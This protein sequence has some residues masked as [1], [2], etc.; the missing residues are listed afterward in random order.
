LSPTQ[1]YATLILS[2]ETTIGSHNSM[3]RTPFQQLSCRVLL[4]ED[5][6][7]QAEVTAEFI[8]AY[9]LEVRI[10]SSGQHALEMA[11]TFHPEIVL[12]D[13]TLPD[14]SGLDVL[15]AMRSLESTRN[16]LL[17]IYS[18]RSQRDLNLL[19]LSVDISA[20]DVFLTKPI[21][22]ENLDMLQS[23]LHGL[24]RRT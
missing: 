4:V 12:C 18:A 7:D 20:V 2:A 15:Q 22:P 16:A 13:L 11:S 5:N 17:V 3:S 19:K 14:L 10:A 1:F 23:R 24:R 8:Q 9:G 6:A 21:T